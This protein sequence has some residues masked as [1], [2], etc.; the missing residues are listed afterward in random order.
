MARLDDDKLGTVFF[1]MNDEANAWKRVKFSHDNVICIRSC[2]QTAHF[3]RED[4][5]ADFVKARAAERAI[6][7]YHEQMAKSEGK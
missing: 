6:Q 4:D 3:E 7:F 1:V 5:A 2:G